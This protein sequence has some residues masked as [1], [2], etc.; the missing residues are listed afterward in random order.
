MTANSLNQKT[1]N[2][3][4]GLHIRGDY[5]CPACR[6]AVEGEVESYHCTGCKREFPILFGIPDFRLRGD[7]YLSISDERKKA[8]KLHAYGET[9]SFLELVKEYYR[10]TEDVSDT[11]AEKFSAYVEAGVNR[12]VAILDTLAVD[13]DGPFIDLGCATGGFLVAA[14]RQS[15]QVVGVDIA[16]RW[17]V[18]CSKRLQEENLDLEIVCADV[19]ALPFRSDSFSAVV[20]SDLLEHVTDQ[21]NAIRSMRDIMVDKGELFVSGANRFT[22]GP[23]P[24]AGLWGV[25]FL[26]KTIRSAHITKICGIDTIRN[27][28]LLSPFGVVKLF[29][30]IGYSI[31]SLS[32]LAVGP[33]SDGEVSLM[34]KHL[35]PIY[36]R[37]RT[38][39]IFKQLLVLI[40][41]AFEMVAT[42]RLVKDEHQKNHA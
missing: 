27:V 29:K 40:G 38:W 19:E 16:L 26:P 7:A 1:N 4:I 2:E 21:K 8:A 23:Y 37:L 36:S 6:S 10:I 12:G 13:H 24:L 30:D 32:P 28:T 5:I 25:G 22:I 15:V 42:K 17:L 41:P 34:R 20:A 33:N 35:L 11:M 18:I 9:H 14:S 39:P 31:K 3:K